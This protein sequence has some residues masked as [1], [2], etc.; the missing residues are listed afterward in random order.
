MTEQELCKL[1]EPFEER[2][3]KYKNKELHALSADDV[4]GMKPAYKAINELYAGA[5]PRIFNA[6][7][8]SCVAEAFRQFI[9]IWDRISTKYVLP[10]SK[11]EEKT[12]VTKSKK[13]FK[14]G[15]K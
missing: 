3:N 9:L 13:T 1:L 7:C 2:F 10:E 11:V 5:L 15:N 14:K 8:G 4:E 12:E 6:S